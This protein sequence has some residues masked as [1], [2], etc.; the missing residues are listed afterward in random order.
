MKAGSPNGRGLASREL[1]RFTAST[2]SDSAGLPLVPGGIQI[3][4]MEEQG[5]GTVSAWVAVEGPEPTKGIWKL[6]LTGEE[7]KIVIFELLVPDQP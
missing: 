4:T 6:R 7:D 5:D 3:V 1:A 2:K